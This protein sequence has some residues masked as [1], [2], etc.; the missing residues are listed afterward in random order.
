MFVQWNPSAAH[1]DVHSEISQTADKSA[2]R[3][4]VE[5]PVDSEFCKLLVPLSPPP[6]VAIRDADDLRQ[7]LQRGENVAIALFNAET[8]SIGRGQPYNCAVGTGSD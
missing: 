4:I 8:D 3:V 2:P 5:T 1:C 7:Y 6:H